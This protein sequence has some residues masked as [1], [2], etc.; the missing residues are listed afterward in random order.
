MNPV[1]SPFLLMK[2]AF[3]RSRL[4]WSDPRSQSTPCQDQ[5]CCLRGR[6]NVWP[7]PVE[8]ASHPRRCEGRS[9]NG[10]EAMEFIRLYYTI[11]YYTI[12]YY[13]ILYYYNIRMYIIV[14]NCVYIYIY[15]CV[16]DSWLFTLTSIMFAMLILFHICIHMYIHTFTIFKHANIYIYIYIYIY[17]HTC[18]YII[19]IYT[20]MYLLLF[21]VLVVPYF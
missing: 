16:Y 1:K 9:W 2:S 8:R 19:Y 6:S 21:V 12:L 10:R 13:T 14:I 5:S 17:T 15:M 7:R 11:L 18:V 4:P 20:H 3:F